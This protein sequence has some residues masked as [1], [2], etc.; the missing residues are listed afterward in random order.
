MQ[1]VFEP[2]GQNVPTIKTAYSHTSKAVK[3]L[4]WLRVDMYDSN[5]ISD[6]KAAVTPSVT[7]SGTQNRSLMQCIGPVQ[8]IT[9][10]DS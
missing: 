7:P 10:G 2:A 4:V 3:T 1:T 6:S 5:S 8:Y 9:K